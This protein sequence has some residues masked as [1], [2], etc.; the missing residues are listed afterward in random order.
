MNKHTKKVA[1]VVG[2][3]ALLASSTAMALSLTNPLSIKSIETDATSGT[4]T[5][6]SGCTGN[7]SITY[8]QFT[9]VPAGANPA[10]PACTTSTDTVVLYS[11]QGQAEAIK[12][13]SSIAT[14]AFL[15]GK[16]VRIF[17]DGTCSSGYARVVSI[18]MI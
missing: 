12:S 17:Y 6:S 2:M 13:M 10:A 15:A 3:L 5:G 18:Q 1:G 14:A 7:G 4:C 16:T 9:T 11:P 8:V